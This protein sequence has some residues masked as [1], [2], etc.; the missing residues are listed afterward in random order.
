MQQETG[1]EDFAAAMRRLRT[2]RGLSL[3]E[4]AIAT[5][6]SKSHLSNVEHGRK[7]P[8]RDLAE[9]LDRVLKAGGELRHLCEAPAPRPGQRTGPCPYRGLAVFEQGD[10]RWFFGR[11]KATALLA[12]RVRQAARDGGPVVV[13]G[14]SGAGK[15]SLLRAGML[16]QAAEG[17]LGGGDWQGVVVTPGPRPVQALADA[18]APA[19]HCSKEVIAEQIRVGDPPPGM[20]RILLVVDQLEEA[21]SLCEDPAERTVFLDALCAVPLGVLAVRADYVDHCLTHPGLVAALQRPVALGGMSRSELTEAIERPAELAGLAVEPGLVDVLLRDLDPGGH[22]YDPGALPLLSHALLTTWQQRTGKRLTIA[23]YHRTGGIR[24][25]VAETAERTYLDLSGEDR[26]AA[27]C[28]MLRLV[29]VGEEGSDTRRRADRGHLGMEEERALAAFTQARLLTVDGTAV[30]ISHE[31]LLRAWPRLAGWI[32]ADRDGIRTHQRLAEAARTWKEADRA[33]ELLLQGAGLAVAVQW[34][35]DRPHQAEEIEREFLAASTREARRGLRRLRRALAALVGLT[36]LLMAVAGF[37]VDRGLTAAGQ[38]RQATARAMAE[39]TTVL[40]ATDPALAATLAL[41]AYRTDPGEDQARQALLSSSGRPYPQVITGN[42]AAVSAFAAGRQGSAA[43]RLFATGSQQGLVRLWR[44]HG[45]VPRPSA[46]LSLGSDHPVFGLGFTHDGRALVIANPQEVRVWWLRGTR[47]LLPGPRLHSSGDV[48]DARMSPDGRLFAAAYHDGTLRLWDL[49]DPHHPGPVREL[50]ADRRRLVSVSFSRDASRIA[51]GDSDGA[52]VIW[53]HTAHGSYR[54]VDVEPFTQAVVEAALAPDGRHLAVSLADGALWLCDLD[55]RGACPRPRIAPYGG[56]YAAG[57]AYSPDGTRLGEADALGPL[58]LRDPRT[59]HVQLTLLSP[60]PLQSLTWAPDRPVLFTGSADGGAAHLWYFP[61]P[62]LLGHTNELT[63]IAV[64]TE[65]G[66][67]ATA[68]HD[69]TVRLWSIHDPDHPVARSVLAHHG[70]VTAVALAP[71]GRRVAAGTKDGNV[72]LWDTADP[73]GPLHTD[74]RLRERVSSLAFTPDGRRLAAAST[75]GSTALWDLTGKQD[76]LTRRGLFTD[77]KVTGVSDVAF[78]AGGRLLVTADSDQRARIWDARAQGTVRSPLHR[79]PGHDS[80]VTTVATGGPLLATG[81]KDDTVRL[82][83]FD[84]QHPLRR[85][86]PASGAL[87][88]HT[89][90]LVGL[91][92][93]ADGHTLLSAAQDGTAIVWNTT[94]PQRPTVTNT[95]HSPGE[96][97]TDAAIS[98][99]GD[100]VWTTAGFTGRRWAT[101]PAHTADLMCARADT[102][103]ARREWES[104]LPDFAYRPLCG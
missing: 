30:E 53:A 86:A 26:A 33:P 42:G 28:L 65:H 85:P 104:R 76:H 100:Q 89:A 73:T 95:L 23:G 62:L 57:L 24:G 83:Q 50:T 80:L 5:R 87:R 19:T 18:L 10:A 97:F 40:R 22:G 101:D 1:P 29:R 49:T 36:V 35:A 15:S 51:T 58:R 99:D 60:R 78:A 21:F 12:G 16:C 79:L 8:H 47:R 71:D 63:S 52:A 68:S 43:E 98:A 55:S 69:H 4:L 34:A 81:A 92:F 90:H 72:H 17:S 27:R 91:A 39:R 88:P 31:A 94:Q 102:L 75:S 37:A 84:L 14:A 96:T 56:N 82:W 70:P 46:E 2:E 11:E 6:Y 32:D 41:A 93:T 74:H 59:G 3:A 48:R 54:A 9:L 20:D 64:R 67:A 13:V 61:L 66:L 38:A 25:A 103:P 7:R 77:A 44:L 45:A